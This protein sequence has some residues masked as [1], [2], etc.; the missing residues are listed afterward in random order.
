[1][2]SLIRMKTAFWNTWDLWTMT[3][4]FAVT[5]TIAKY[6]SSLNLS[7]NIIADRMTLNLYA[8][9]RTRWQETKPVLGDAEVLSRC[10]RKG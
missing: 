6:R 10:Y 3:K 9:C 2:T 4:T 7:R 5:A 1:M 8:Q